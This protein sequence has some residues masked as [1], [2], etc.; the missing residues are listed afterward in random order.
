MILRDLKLNGLNTLTFL[1]TCLLDSWYFISSSLSFSSD[2]TAI[3]S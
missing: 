1:D 2:L 3:L